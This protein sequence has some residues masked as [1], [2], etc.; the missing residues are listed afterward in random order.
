ML[1]VLVIQKRELSLTANQNFIIKTF[2]ENRKV[3]KKYYTFFF[4]IFPFPSQDQI[5]G[6]TP[7]VFYG[8]R[9]NGRDV[10]HYFRIYDDFRTYSF[11]E[12]E[13]SFAC[14]TIKPSVN[15]E[16]GLP[17]SDVSKVTYWLHIRQR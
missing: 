4:L 17:I 14:H 1:S 10:I 7:L 6:K 12:E 11:E 9:R 3:F 13:G 2:S 15:Y 5:L 16:I 8:L